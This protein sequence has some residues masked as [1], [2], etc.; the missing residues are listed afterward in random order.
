MW[1]I[2]AIAIVGIV[3]ISKYVAK[4]KRKEELI[5]EEK[6]LEIKLQKREEEYKSRVKLAKEKNTITIIG[7][8]L[9]K[10]FKNLSISK[11][12]SAIK[13]SGQYTY[14]KQIIDLYGSIDSIK[15]YEFALHRTP[16]PIYNTLK[17]ARAID[18]INSFEYND[19]ISTFSVDPRQ[20]PSIT[21]RINGEEDG[22]LTIFLLQDINNC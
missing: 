12:T 2:V 7:P 6:E 19:E 20:I 13:I 18:Y 1:I 11:Y 21:S 8:G 22:V 14:L 16:S 5:K 10:V 3:L 9:Y 4:E 17:R 15:S